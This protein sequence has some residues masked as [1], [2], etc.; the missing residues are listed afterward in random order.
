M[1]NIELIEPLNLANDLNWHIIRA[2]AWANEI[3]MVGN[4]YS[5]SYGG[6]FQLSNTGAAGEITDLR[7]NREGDVVLEG[8]ALHVQL[9]DILRVI[10]AG[11]GQREILEFVLRDNDFVGGSAGDDWIGTMSGADRIFAGGGNDVVD[12]GSGS[13]TAVYRGTK[14]D[15]TIVRNADG[16]FAVTDK[17]AGRDGADTLINVEFLQFSDQVFALSNDLSFP[18]LFAANL[19]QAKAIVATYQTLLG[20]I[21]GMAGFEFLIKTNLSTNFGAGHASVFNDESIY[22]NV[23]NSLIQGNAAADAK[24]NS[25]AAGAT[26]SEK[27]AS[28]YESIIPAGKQTAEGLAFLTRPDALHFYQDVAEARGITSESGPAIV[29]MASLLKVTV[30]GKIGIGNP[31]SDLIAAIADGSST[32]PATSSSLLPIET[33]DGSK[34][35][36][37]DDADVMPGF[38]GHEPAPAPAPLIGI[39]QDAGI[40]F[41][42]AGF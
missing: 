5:A 17:N 38:W 29:A 7:I 11:G 12:G 19:S 39:M 35:D 32:L 41:E 27:I 34:L 13:D 15:Y 40:M 18:A 6:T 33:V 10:E 8:S 20:G 36:A 28:L 14:A 24:F 2:D 22:I 25:L 3:I 16:S 23:L 9:A 37:D 21:P 26:L 1:A 31:V 4:R 30:D 42:A